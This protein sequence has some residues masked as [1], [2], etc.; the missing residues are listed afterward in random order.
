MKPKTRKRLGAIIFGSLGAVL[1]M[2]I[3]GA[4]IGVP[5]ALYGLG[6]YVQSRNLNDEED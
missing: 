3:V 4:I 5:M 1:T 6:L 2:T